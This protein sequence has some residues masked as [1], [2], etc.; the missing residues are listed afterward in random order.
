M[1][2]STSARRSTGTLA[3]LG[4]AVLGA[5]LVAAPAA[6]PSVSMPVGP[7]Q[8]GML[9]LT[10]PTSPASTSTRARSLYAQVLAS[11]VPSLFS[12]SQEEYARVPV[13]TWVPPSTRLPPSTKLTLVPSGSE[14]A[15]QP[16]VSVASPRPA[17]C[18]A[19]PT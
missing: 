2:L 13:P 3:V 8:N 1:S 15:L 11:V 6:V 9:G 7:P 5:A 12:V 19:Y 10:L 4:S 17:Q 16:S 18:A 14:A